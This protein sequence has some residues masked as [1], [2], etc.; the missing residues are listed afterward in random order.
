MAPACA[1]FPGEAQC[2]RGHLF[3]CGNV[4][5]LMFYELII[6]AGVRPCVYV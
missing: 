5:L 2:D 4:I 1:C 6:I 3:V